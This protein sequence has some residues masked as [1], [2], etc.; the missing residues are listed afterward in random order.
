MF[1]AGK[2]LLLCYYYARCYALGFVKVRTFVL[3]YCWVTCKLNVKNHMKKTDKDCDPDWKE[4]WYISA[5]SPTPTSHKFIP[6]GSGAQLFW[7]RT[8]FT[9]HVTACMC[10]LKK[11]RFFAPTLCVHNIPW[12]CWHPNATVADERVKFQVPG[13]LWSGL[14]IDRT[15][16]LMVYVWLRV[17]ASPEAEAVLCFLGVCLW[18]VFI[19]VP[20]SPDKM[21]SSQFLW[22]QPPVSH[23]MTAV[24]RWCGYHLT[25]LTAPLAN[26]VLTWLTVLL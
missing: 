19:R 10:I 12:A 24:C 21:S 13:L 3:L 7:S 25:W 18:E 8:G 14:A 4:S 11:M 2:M 1:T 22:A 17:M 20:T 6:H 15:L 23:H 9:R 5:M 16:G 26:S